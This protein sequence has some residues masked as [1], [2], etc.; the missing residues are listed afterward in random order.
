[1]VNLVKVTVEI[2]QEL[3]KKVEQQ[4]R[5]HPDFAEYNKYKTVKDYVAGEIE[6][7]LNSNNDFIISN[8]FQEALEKR[9]IKHHKP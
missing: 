6:L 7:A 9:G 3:Y 1:M 8:A 4:L 5:D 2:P